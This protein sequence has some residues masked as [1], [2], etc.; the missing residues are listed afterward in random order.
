MLARPSLT[1]P[2]EWELRV[3]L[4]ACYRLFD[5]LGWTEMIFNH[6][7]MRVPGPEHHFLINPFGL[8][9][10]EVTASNLVKVDLD[11]NVIGRSDYRVNRA[12]FVIHSAIHAAVPTALCIMHTHT[13]AGL[14]VASSRRGLSA[15]NFYGATVLDAISYHDFE[16][17]SVHDDEKARLVADLGGKRAMILRN[18]GLLVHGPRRVPPALS[19]QSRLRGATGDRRARRGDRAFGRD[20]RALRRPH[21]QRLQPQR[22]PALRCDGSASR[23]ARHVLSELAEPAHFIP[24]ASAVTARWSKSLAKPMN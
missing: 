3:D 20:P 18:H 16:G 13:T 14:A 22:A 7:S 2:S 23:P 8:H 15:N 12:G 9:Y 24:L 10:S 4:A 1:E 11:G 6:I 19:A 17:P 5:H 21:D